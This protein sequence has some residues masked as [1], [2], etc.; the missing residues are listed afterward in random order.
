MGG[1][2]RRVTGKGGGR[3]LKGEGMG[4]LGRKGAEDKRKGGKV[5]SYV[6]MNVLKTPA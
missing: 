4:W 6:L 1:D 2:G 5:V 3:R